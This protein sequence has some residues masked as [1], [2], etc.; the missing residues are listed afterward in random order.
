VTSVTRHEKN[1][2]ALPCA[3][4]RSAP[5]TL[6]HCHGG[7][8]REHGWSVGMG[9]RQNPFLQIPLKAEYHV[10]RFGIDYG[11][12]VLSWERD[13]GTQW[14]HLQWVNDQLDYDIFQL[15]LDWQNRH[16]SKSS[17]T[18]TRR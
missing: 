6:H 18:G 17:S 12:G 10:G 13:F 11:Y 2:R 8:M 3:V 5:V 15:A 9:Q 14:E 7:S 16:R 4:T 1:L